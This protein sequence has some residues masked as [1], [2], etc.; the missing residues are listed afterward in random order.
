MAAV[1][2]APKA[3]STCATWAR[4]TYRVRVRRTWAAIGELAEKRR[5]LASLVLD[6]LLA[7]IP[8]ET[9]ARADFLVEFHFEETAPG[10]RPRPAA[11][12]GIERC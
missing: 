9:P 7:K 6:T 8:S 3:A 2:P 11:A 5:R 10:H 12:R 4:D 1:S